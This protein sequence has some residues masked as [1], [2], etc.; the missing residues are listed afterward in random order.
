M[1]KYIFG[2]GKRRTCTSSIS[3]SSFFLTEIDK[4]DTPKTLG[5]DFIAT[6]GG[7]TMVT[8]K[9]ALSLSSLIQMKTF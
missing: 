5:R 2:N 6:T 4:D 3:Y 8:I 9:A 7:T 1:R